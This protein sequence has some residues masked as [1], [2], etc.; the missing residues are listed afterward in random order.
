MVVFGQKRCH[1]FSLPCSNVFLAVAKQIFS[2]CKTD[3]ATAYHNSENVP[4]KDPVP[5]NGTPRLTK[6][7]G[8][9]NQERY[10]FLVILPFGSSHET[11]NVI[12][13]RKKVKKNSRK[14]AIIHYIQ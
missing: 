9:N 8:Q 10:K 4:F 5:L 14:K 11:S 7:K 3:F 2:S 12:S 1:A 6:K 13:Q